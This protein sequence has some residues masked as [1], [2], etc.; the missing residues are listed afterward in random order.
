MTIERHT[1]MVNIGIVTESRSTTLHINTENTGKSTLR[2]VD[3]YTVT[4]PKYFT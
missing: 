4:S 3:R 2:V 1:S